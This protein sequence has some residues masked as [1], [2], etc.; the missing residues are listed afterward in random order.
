MRKNPYL[1]HSQNIKL[2]PRSEAIIKKAKHYNVIVYGN[3]VL[4][5]NLLNPTCSNVKI[6]KNM[7]EFFTWLQE[8]EKNTQMSKN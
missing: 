8:Q 2:D 4:G 5:K 6:Q 3:T 1:A 7:L